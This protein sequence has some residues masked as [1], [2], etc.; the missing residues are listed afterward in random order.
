MIAERQPGKTTQGDEYGKAA[1]RRAGVMAS[2]VSQLTQGGSAVKAGASVGSECK[3]DKMRAAMSRGAS[4]AMELG[5][6]GG[7]P[8]SLVSSLLKNDIKVGRVTTSKDAGGR[9]RYRLTP[10]FE[11]ALEQSLRDAAALL[12][13]HGWSV[14][15][16]GSSR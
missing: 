13:R 16:D 7:I 11:D 1:C 10:G 12:R 6:A 4:M 2:L 8:S 15:R 3:T 14:V 5:Q 9:T